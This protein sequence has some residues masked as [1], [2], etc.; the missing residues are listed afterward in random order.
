MS[1]VHYRPNG[2]NKAEAGARLLDARH[3]LTRQIEQLDWQI[4]ALVHIGLNTP[5]V[6]S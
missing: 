2:D 4:D 3:D 6:I 1:L 5:R